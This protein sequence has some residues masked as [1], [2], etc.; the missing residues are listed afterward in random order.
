ME[1]VKNDNQ[2]MTREYITTPTQTAVVDTFYDLEFHTEL[3]VSK[4]DIKVNDT[5]QIKATIYNYLNKIQKSYSETI[6]FELDGQHQEI[7]PINGTATIEFSSAISGTYIIR[8]I[9]DGF[10]NAI[11]EVAVCE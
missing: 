5:V 9:N 2:I 1:Y 11:M 8:T 6:I 4:S 10:R 7:V 3:S